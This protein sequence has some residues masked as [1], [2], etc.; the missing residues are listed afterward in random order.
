MK[1]VSHSL[2]RCAKHDPPLLSEQPQLA[3]PTSSRRCR[4]I[5]PRIA[6]DTFTKTQTCLIAAAGRIGQSRCA[7][8]SSQN[9]PK[10]S[11]GLHGSTRLPPCLT[12]WT[13]HL[14]SE[15]R[16]VLLAHVPNFKILAR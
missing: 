16:L 9:W 2:G 15:P 1:A 14:L 8:V 10:S 13:C 4:V 7:A 11:L 5:P 6:S 12:R 3:L